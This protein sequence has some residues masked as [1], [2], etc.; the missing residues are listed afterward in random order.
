MQVQVQ[1]YVADKDEV[2]RHIWAL[3]EDEGV[4]RFPG[5]W[6]RIPNFDGAGQA[7]EQL[8]C[9]E[10]WKQARA[11]KANPDAPQL[12]V[13]KAALAD[14]KTVY[15]AVPRL[16]QAE[17]FMELNPA[18]LD[19]PLHKAA[20]IKGAS[21]YGRPVSPEDLARIDLVVAGSVAVSRDGSRVGKGRGYSDL[22]FAI[23]VELGKLH[24]DTPVVTTVHSLQVCEEP[25]PMHPHDISLDWIVTPKGAIACTRPY[26]RPA[27][28]QWPLL[29][30]ERV[31]E[32][33][34]LAALW[35]GDGP[36]GTGLPF[37]S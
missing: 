23:L 28:V 6:G 22:E 30:R 16:R 37:R 8:R 1:T 35:S 27:G 24:P 4:A 29:S 36:T 10:V 25:L 34:V 31:S 32:I 7:A 15:M 9:L 12:P 20:T 19:V 17:A 3:L 13:R 11:I 18:A 14:G 33:P 2:R 21:R 5:A 26:A